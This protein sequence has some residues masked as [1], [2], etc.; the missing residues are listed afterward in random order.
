MKEIG[1]TAH[2]SDQHR[3]GGSEP[4]HAK[5]YLGFEYAVDRSTK[6]QAFVKAANETE[7]RRRKWRR[8]SYA[9]QFF[10]WET[11][12]ARECKCVKVFFGDQQHGFVAASAQHFGPGN[13]G[14][15]VFT[16]PPS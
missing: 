13:P 16:G 9:W 2:S 6:R 7:N 3:C 10:E 5:H 15:K 14:K 1:N 11:R 4:A 12:P 8:Q